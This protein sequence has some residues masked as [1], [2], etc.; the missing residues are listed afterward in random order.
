MKI[1]FIFYIAL[2]IILFNTT[3][4]QW[5]YNKLIEKQFG[6]ILIDGPQ[7]I[8]HNSIIKTSDNCYLI[9]GS[10]DSPV[11]GTKTVDNCFDSTMQA[12]IWADAYVIKLDSNLNVIWEKVYGGS[13]IDYFSSCVELPDG[14]FICGGPSYSDS[15][16]SKSQNNLG[17]SSDNWIVRM[18]SMGIILWDKRLGGIGE[19]YWPII[20]PTLDSGFLI[21]SDSESPVGWSVTDSSHGGC[22]IW[23][24]KLG[25][26]GFKQWDKM[27]GSF[28][29]DL[30][31]YAALTSDGNC[32]ILGNTQSASNIGE[33]DVSEPPYGPY[34]TM[35]MWMFKIDSIG[36]ILWDKRLGG[37]QDDIPS[38]FLE[39]PDKNLI[40]LGGMESSS[41]GGTIIDT[42][43]YGMA[44]AII[45]LADS[46]GQPITDKIIGGNKVSGFNSI[47]KSNNG[48][49]ILGGV[50]NCDIGYYKSEYCRGQFDYWIMETDSSF[51]PIWDKTLG[52]NYYDGYL[53]VATKT[54]NELIA[55]G[56][57]DSDS[58]GDKTIQNIGVPWN[59][60]D[61]W[62]VVFKMDT[63]TSINNLHG[64][65]NFKLFPNPALQELNIVIDGITNQNFD[66][67]IYDTQGR[68]LKNIKAEKSFSN[69]KISI[70]DLTPGVYLVKVGNTA[71]RFVKM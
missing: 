71:R 50:S 27:Y 47:S 6:G 32:L 16:C 70:S 31:K 56:Y 9:Y 12:G 26:N 42:N 29:N 40:L 45:I 7:S 30:V 13:D 41:L 46:M 34:P 62:I 53:T 23:V 37:S 39:K 35:D 2:L 69:F 67:L 28:E 20:V 44:D 19:E 68:Q 49:L 48:N 1:K 52:G 24:V 25:K 38:C 36:N 61:F 57:S 66:V 55:C 14:G 63:I 5:N 43:R 21:I 15:S 59:L 33:N 64:L 18:D 65:S 51:N 8:S 60:G 58:S 4:A 22:D 17:F 54:N 3:S 10:S 11:S